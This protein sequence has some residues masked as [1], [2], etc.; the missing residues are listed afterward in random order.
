MSLCLRF[1]LTSTRLVFSCVTS[2]QLREH[3]HRCGQHPYSSDSITSSR[4][5]SSRLS[6]CVCCRV[7]A[8]MADRWLVYTTWSAACSRTTLNNVSGP[9]QH[10]PGHRF[11]QRWR[12][13]G[14]ARSRFTLLVRPN[15]APTSAIARR[16]LPLRRQNSELL[17][18][19]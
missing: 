7:E 4:S 3:L 10:G 19:G 14:I 11:N 18:E 17:S 15:N 1:R 9:A 5:N 6:V 16:S 2:R 8:S 12:P 13:K